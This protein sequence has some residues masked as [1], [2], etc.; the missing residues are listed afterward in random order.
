VI[1]ALYLLFLAGAFGGGVQAVRL[2]LAHR[3]ASR[4]KPRRP[5]WHE[6]LP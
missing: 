4:V 2:A 3:A 1:W 6:D 5:G